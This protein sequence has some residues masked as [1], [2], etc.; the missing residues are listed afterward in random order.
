MSAHCGGVN[1]SFPDFLSP[2]WGAP[3]HSELNMKLKVERSGSGV[4]IHHL[5]ASAYK[6]YL[7]L[8][9]LS[10]LQKSIPDFR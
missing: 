10:L 4:K 8:P 1:K 9:Y 3:V 7:Y 2:T 6:A 5:L